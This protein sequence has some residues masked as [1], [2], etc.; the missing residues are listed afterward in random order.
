MELVCSNLFFSVDFANDK[1]WVVRFELNEDDLDY[2]RSARVEFD[3]QSLSM[4]SLILVT[5]I[6]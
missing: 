4:V 1:Y 3:T 2:L 6:Y 5:I